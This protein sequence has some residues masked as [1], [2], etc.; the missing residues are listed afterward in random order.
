MARGFDS[1]AVESQQ[2]DLRAALERRGAAAAPPDPARKAMELARAR[3]AAD[4][5]KAT[6]P[7]HRQ[8]LEAALADLDRSL[9]REGPA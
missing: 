9:R 6:Q 3:V 2:D 8:M 1:K 4:L 5:V 7:A